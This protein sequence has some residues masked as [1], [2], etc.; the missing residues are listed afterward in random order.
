MQ[1]HH[2]AEKTPVVWWFRDG[3]AGHDNQSRG[4]IIALRR[5]IALD[6]HEVPLPSWG[7]LLIDAVAANF[8]GGVE[9]PDPDVLIGAGHATHLPLLAAR[10]ARGGRSIVLMKPSLPRGWF[11]L[12][13]IPRHDGVAAAPNVLV[14]DGLLNTIQASADKVPDRGLMLIGGPSVHHRW[15][16][17]EL[18]EQ[19]R[20]IVARDPGVHWVIVSSRRTPAD[21][22]DALRALASA[23]VDFI[24]HETTEAA[25][26]PAQLARAAT[27]WVSEDSVS[28]LYEALT[29]GAATGVLAAPRRG[30]DRVTQAIDELIR[31]ARVTPFADWQAG[32]SLRAADGFNEAARVAVWIKQ[33]WLSEC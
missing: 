29:A 2:A 25:W 11:D 30:A 14:T 18:I 26:L 21:T 6:L 32:R 16:N 4:L 15:S 27:V 23:Q 3:K 13:I 33:T 7:R 10:R 17:R 8:Q 20:V 19:L 9:L 24:H 12:C 28:M 31:S 22:V 1:S 5:L